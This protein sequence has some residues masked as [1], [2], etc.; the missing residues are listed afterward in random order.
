MDLV[1]CICQLDP[2]LQAQS[3]RVRDPKAQF[4][5]VVLG[6]KPSFPEDQQEETA[7]RHPG[8]H[9]HLSW[10]KNQVDTIDRPSSVPCLTTDRKRPVLFPSRPSVVCKSR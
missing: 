6:K 9:R 1:C 3:A 7:T 10:T 8:K 2:A 4:S 5:S